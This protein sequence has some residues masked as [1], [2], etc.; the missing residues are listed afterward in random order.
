MMHSKAANLK[1]HLYVFFKENTPCKLI[2]NVCSLEK[3]AIR[4][5]V[6]LD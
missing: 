2:S 4:I 6:S 1:L 5:V 3:L